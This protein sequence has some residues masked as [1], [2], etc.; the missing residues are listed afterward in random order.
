MQVSY[1]DGVLFY[2]LYSALL[3]FVNRKLEVIPEHFSK[4]REYTAM[5]PEKRLAVRDVLFAQRELIDDFIEEN[6]ASLSADELTVVTSWKN[7]LVGKFYI[8][9][10]LTK[11][12]VFLSSGGSPNK[13]YG[14]LA[15]ATR[16]EVIGPYLPRLITTVLLPFRGT[17]IY[18]GLVSGYNISFGGGIKRMLNEEYKQAKEAFGIVT[19]LPFEGEEPNTTEEDEAVIVTYPSPGETQEVRIGSKKEPAFPLR[20]TQAQ[21]QVVA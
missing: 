14:V 21:R 9:R 11:Y 4:S 7:A 2:K 8:F 10:Y 15:L 17:I 6:P 12:T 16:S 3:G 1:D 20:L 18:D 5:P 13:A 19:S